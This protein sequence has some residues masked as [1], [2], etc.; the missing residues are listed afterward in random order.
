MARS[1]SVVAPLLL[2]AAAAYVLN[3]GTSFVAPPKAADAALQQQQQAPGLPSV[4][5][6]GHGGGQIMLAQPNN[7]AVVWCFYGVFTALT[8]LDRSAAHDI[9]KSGGNER[10]SAHSGSHADPGLGGA[11]SLGG[12]NS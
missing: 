10:S 1:S 2:L 12:R 9:L 6:F 3:F 4:E 5:Q 11:S 8:S 7:D